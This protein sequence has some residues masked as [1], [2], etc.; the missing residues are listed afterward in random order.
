MRPDYGTRLKADGHGSPDAEH[1]FYG[2]PIRGFDALGTAGQYTLTTDAT[3]AGT[4]HRLSLD[5]GPRVLAAILAA[6][7]PSIA[8]SI[9]AELQ[10]DP[11]SPR[12]FNFPHEIHCASITATLGGTQ[13]GSLESFTPMIVR[14]ISLG[15]PSTVTG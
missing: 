10:R 12:Q 3:Y 11:N 6:L 4:P 1:V 5:F 14:D 2:L 7:P 13:H 15:S 8:R 9:D